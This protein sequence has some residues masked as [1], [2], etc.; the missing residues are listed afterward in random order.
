M[1]L[2]LLISGA[3]VFVPPPSVTGIISISSRI[4]AAISIEDSNTVSIDTIDN[5]NITM[6]IESIT[7]PEITQLDDYNITIDINALVATDIIFSGL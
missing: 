5:I 6:E 7:S 4:P 1:S 3:F 2:L